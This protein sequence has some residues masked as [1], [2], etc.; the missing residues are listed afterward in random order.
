M[1]MID[2][3]NARL[4]LL[5]ALPLILAL[6]LSG[7]A[8]TGAMPGMDHAPESSSASPAPISAADQMFVTMM[9]P[10]HEQAI[11]MSDVI[12]EKEGV[13]ERVRTLAEEIKAAQGPEI[14]RMNEWLAEWGV[15]SDGH[16][17]MDHGDGM[18]SAE[19]M[20]NLEAANGADAARLFLEQMIVH[21]EGAVEMAQVAVE[22]GEDPDVRALAQEVIDAQQIE[23][24]TMRD[25]LTQL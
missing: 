17:G 5:A 2:R 18:M 6:G 16:A 11:E 1:S 20:A 24:A 9:I 14:E 19:D 25:L 10:H 12:L 23:I 3:K 4:A 8:N 22:N 21:H 13:D 15:G 7:C